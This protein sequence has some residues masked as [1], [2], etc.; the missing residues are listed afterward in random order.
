LI[1]YRESGMTAACNLQIRFELSQSEGLGFIV[2]GFTGF[3]VSPPTVP[4]AI[5]PTLASWPLWSELMAV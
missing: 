1:E 3:S 4:K 5:I 2:N